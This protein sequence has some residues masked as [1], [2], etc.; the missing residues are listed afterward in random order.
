MSPVEKKSES[1]LPE[2]PPTSLGKL[3]PLRKPGGSS[4]ATSDNFLSAKNKKQQI[5]SPKKKE[6]EKRDPIPASA[7]EP[8]K[9]VLTESITEESIEEELACESLGKSDGDKSEEGGGSTF[10]ETISKRSIGADYVEKF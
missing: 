3:P 5:E 2:S 6:E 1:K 7:K 4:N 10:E 9:D 8:E